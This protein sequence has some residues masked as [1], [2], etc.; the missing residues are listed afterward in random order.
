[1]KDFSIV[2][3][4]I[5]ISE[6]R[7]QLLKMP[8]KM[9]KGGHAKAMAVTRKGKPVLAILP[10]DLY[11]SIIETLEIIEDEELISLLRLSIKQAA[12]SKT[13]PWEKVKR[14]LEL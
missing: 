2:E 4:S 5:T 3:D 7:S 14:E 12:A 11:E 13:I 1:M 6:A 9:S 10:W 8:G